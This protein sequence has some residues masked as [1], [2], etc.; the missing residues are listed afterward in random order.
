MAFKLRIARVLENTRVVAG[1]QGFQRRGPAFVVQ[2][3]ALVLF[4][5]GF[6][7]CV[8]IRPDL[9]SRRL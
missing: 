1:V 5:I 4:G 7:P 2:Q 9:L 8:Q 3:A 6:R